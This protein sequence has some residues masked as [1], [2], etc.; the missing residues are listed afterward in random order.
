MMLSSFI[1]VAGAALEPETSTDGGP[2]SEAMQLEVPRQI[3]SVFDGFR[4]RPLRMHH[5]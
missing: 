5:D 3:T 1:D 4:E 2:P